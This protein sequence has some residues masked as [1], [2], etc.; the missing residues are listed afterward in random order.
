MGWLVENLLFEFCNCLHVNLLVGSGLYEDSFCV[1]ICFLARRGA[2]TVIYEI[3]LWCCYVAQIYAMLATRASMRR[4][5]SILQ[6]QGQA[7]NTATWMRMK[8][9]WRDRNKHPGVLAC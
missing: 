7:L 3:S 1:Q 4:Q 6:Q 8:K 5:Q 2:D 9:M